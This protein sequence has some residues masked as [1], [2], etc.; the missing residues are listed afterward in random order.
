METKHTPGPWY[1]DRSI[2][3][4]NDCHAGLFSDL[5]VH[6]KPLNEGHQGELVAGTF[7]GEIRCHPRNARLIAAAPDLLAACQEAIAF[8]AVFAGER[9]CGLPSDNPKAATN[10]HEC[11]RQMQAAIAK[12]SPLPDEVES[13]ETLAEQQAAQTDADNA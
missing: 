5:V 2:G 11:I 4:P 6:G 13:A 8:V 9:E 1:W 12:A 10:A 7:N 3:R